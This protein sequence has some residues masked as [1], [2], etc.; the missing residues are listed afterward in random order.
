M[1]IYHFGLNVRGFETAL[2][3]FA[4]IAIFFIDLDH[5]IIPDFFTLPGIIIGLGFSF[6]PGAFI[7]WT[8]ALI[9]A[10]VG[11]G[12]FFL[13]G[14]VGRLVFKKE[15]LGFGDVKFAAMLGAFI[16]WMDLLLV[17]VLASFFG[18]VVG[19]ALIVF[20]KKGKRS[21]IPFGPFLVIGA[22]LT[23][24]FGDRIIRAYL[25]FVGLAP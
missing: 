17:L 18:S 24:Y 2:L 16:G 23:I 25:E 1:A 15:A 21:Y 12:A 10:A 14:A 13:V 9:G 3:S 20:S 6:I 22:W 4:F 8:Q 7:N 5:T 11:G 19:I